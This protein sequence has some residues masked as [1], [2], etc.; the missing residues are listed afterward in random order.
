M[1]GAEKIKSQFDSLTTKEKII[2]VAMDIIA[3]EGF[4]NITI[5]KIAAKAGVNVAAINYHFGSKDAV[6]N[7]ALKTVTDQLKNTFEYLKASNEIGETR[8]A[9][10]VEKYTDI[11]LK[12]PDIIK[13]MINHA[14]HSKP[15][16]EQVEYL[17]YLK[18]EGIE[19]IKQTIGQIRPDQDDY[20][21]YL[22]TLHLVSGLSFPFLMG[23][24]I[25]VLMG[26]DFYNQE[27]RQMHTKILLENVCRRD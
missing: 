9:I 20:L 15:L 22:K 14:I 8:L 7:E 27:I 12:Y 13:N 26:V 11:M 4:Q 2:R 6:I 17:T 16:D 21:L 23:E 18:T 19:A 24:Q 1:K 3:E 25:N 10:F 5:R